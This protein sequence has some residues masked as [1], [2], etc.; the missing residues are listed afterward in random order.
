M[1]GDRFQ[2]T[3][4]SLQRP[5]P[6]KRIADT[7]ILGRDVR[8]GTQA[9]HLDLDGARGQKQ[10]LALA[11]AILYDPA[12]LLL[13]EATSAVD[14]GTE[15]LIQKALEHVMKGRTSLIIAQRLS[16][17]K[18]ADRIVVLKHGQVVETGT[19]ESLLA[20]NGEY[21]HI[22]NLQYRAQEEGGTAVGHQLSAVG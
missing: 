22:F 2:I 6:T 13:D 18:H 11:R 1:D 17:I 19:H 5:R 16:T 8:Q 15:A 10:R 7:G 14:T 20:L 9:F 3:V 4:C 21:T 12:I